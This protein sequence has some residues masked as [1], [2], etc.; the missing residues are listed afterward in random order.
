MGTRV[1]VVAGM[2]AGDRVIDSPPD[3]IAQGDHVRP[4]ETAPVVKP[5]TP[6][7]AVAAMP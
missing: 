5:K 4:N 3:W 6:T 1:E 2:N 7:P